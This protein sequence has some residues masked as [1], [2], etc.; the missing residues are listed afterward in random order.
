MINYLDRGFDSLN[1]QILIFT[2]PTIT[3]GGNITLTEPIKHY[4]NA[5]SFL[6]LSYGINYSKNSNSV[7]NMRKN[8][9]GELLNIDSLTSQFRTITIIHNLGLTY[10]YTSQRFN[11]NIGFN[12]RPTN[13]KNTN[14]S[15]ASG[16]SISHLS[17]SPTLQMNF[18]GSNRKSLNIKYESSS[19][20]PNLEQLQPL[21]NYTNINNIVVGNPKLKSAINH[22][23]NMTYI[24]GGNNGNSKNYSVNSSIIQNQIVDNTI[25]AAD[26]SNT[27]KQVTRYVNTSGNYSFSGNYRWSFYLR[28]MKYNLEIQGAYNFAHQVSYTNNMKNFGKICGFFQ[29]ASFKAHLSRLQTSSGIY[30]TNRINSFSLSPKQT[31]IQSW[32]FNANLG[33]NIIESLTAHIEYLKTVNIGYYK[34]GNNPVIINDNIEKRLFKS[35]HVLLK[36]EVNDL[37]NQGNILSRT[38]SN[39]ST[40]ESISNK[41][42]RYFYLR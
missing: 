40:T 32:N 9:I 14:T 17:I 16:N 28:Q 7:V 10:R 42:T 3:L 26:S 38:I 5:Q 15:N 13:I 31:S 2:K 4:D 19:L 6:D 21:S 41:V 34:T 8:P 24:K 33:V 1:H 36:L 23:F 39:N 30:Y 22:S 20:L 12:A 35:Q 25:L 18:I 29:S 37:L 11:Y 27:V